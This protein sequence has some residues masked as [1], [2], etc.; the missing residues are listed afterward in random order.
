MHYYLLKCPNYM[1]PSTRILHPRYSFIAPI[2]VLCVNLTAKIQFIKTGSYLSR[3]LLK[4]LESSFRLDY[5]PIVY[6]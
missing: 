5:I 4:S 6:L 1:Y 2:I 3:G